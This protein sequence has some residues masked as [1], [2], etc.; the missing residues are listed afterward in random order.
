MPPLAQSPTGF[1]E[2]L[3]N[4][5]VVIRNGLSRP[6]ALEGHDGSSGQ[7]SKMPVNNSHMRDAGVQGGEVI[8]A[9]PGSVGIH[10]IISPSLG[11]SGCSSNLRVRKE[12]CGEIKNPA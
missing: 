4:E 9:G 7:L 6:E 10:G 12:S 3:S 11:D 5:A 8:F 2:P 1:L